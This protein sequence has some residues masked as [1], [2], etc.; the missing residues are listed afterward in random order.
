[1]GSVLVQIAGDRLWM[2][3]Q[4]ITWSSY[5][6]GQK[7]ATVPEI[8]HQLKK[9]RRRGGQ[10]RTTSVKKKKDLLS[11]KNSTSRVSQSE[12]LSDSC[13]RLKLGSPWDA[14]FSE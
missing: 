7:I 11:L 6:T 9:E 1:M 13:K 2:T 8:Q 5:S 12:A 4:L 10:K 3:L 14:C